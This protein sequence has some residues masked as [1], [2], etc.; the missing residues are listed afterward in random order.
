MSNVEAL[1][2]ELAGEDWPRLAEAIVTATTSPLQEEL[3]NVQEAYQLVGYWYARAKDKK[4]R[5]AA[6]EKWDWQLIED[7]L[8]AYVKGLDRA[9]MAIMHLRKMER[10]QF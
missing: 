3:E 1:M 6:D 10:G 7:V 2:E 4:R 5:A 8:E 9:I